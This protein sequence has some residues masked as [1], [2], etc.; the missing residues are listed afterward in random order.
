MREVWFFLI[1]TNTDYIKES[2]WY[3]TFEEAYEAH[4]K[5]DNPYERIITPI[6]KGYFKE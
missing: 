2:S 1:R 4:C 3:K 5:W 6:M